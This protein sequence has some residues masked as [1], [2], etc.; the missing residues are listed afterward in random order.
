MKKVCLCMLLCLVAAMVVSGGDALAKEV[1]GGSGQ[2]S[3]IV[4]VWG[5]NDI[6]EP[7]G[8]PVV[9]LTIGGQMPNKLGFSET[10]GVSGLL[11]LENL[12]ASGPYSIDGFTYR[13]VKY[14]TN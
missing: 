9:G 12:T 10:T 11:P 2:K 8:T 7:R 6:G 14:G 4:F 3:G 5:D 1:A 13:G